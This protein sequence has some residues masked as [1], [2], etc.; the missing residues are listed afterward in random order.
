MAHLI[1]NAK[2]FLAPMAFLLV[3]G[4]FTGFTVNKRWNDD[5]REAFR[6]ELLPVIKEKRAE[7]DKSLSKKEKAQITKLKDEMK[8]IHEKMVEIR[9]AAKQEQAGAEQKGRRSHSFTEEQRSQLATLQWERKKILSEAFLIADAHKDEVMKL[10]SDIR[11]KALELRKTNRENNVEKNRDG[12]RDR[13]GRRGYGKRG[14]GNVNRFPG[15]RS[16]M[17]FG[18][19]TDPA[20]FILFDEQRFGK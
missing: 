17:M 5:R 6:N 11:E 19:L 8:S 9:Q 13:M 1:K 20:H 10:T 2:F 7:L 3:F 4:L 12:K 14:K 18:M 16:H 15:G